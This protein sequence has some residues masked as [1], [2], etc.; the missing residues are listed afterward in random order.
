[1]NLSWSWRLNSGIVPTAPY[2][3]RLTSRVLRERNVRG[4]RAGAPPVGARS[5]GEGSRRRSVPRGRP[6]RTSRVLMAEKLS[7]ASEQPQRDRS[8][9]PLCLCGATSR[10]QRRRQYTREGRPLR[11][12]SAPSVS[13][14]CYQQVSTVQAVHKRR[15]LLASALCVSVVLTAGANG[16]R[17]R[18]HG[19]AS[20][21]KIRQ[22]GRCAEQAPGQWRATP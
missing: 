7:P 10:C 20:A 3:P 17:G 21:G 18:Q 9:C 22:T 6:A 12:P 19:S 2:T 11:S 4:R 5:D 16:A 1:M 13:L 8:L 15:A 14:W